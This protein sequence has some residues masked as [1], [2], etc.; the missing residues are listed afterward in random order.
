MRARF[1]MV[2]GLLSLLLFAACED[3]DPAGSDAAAAGGKADDAHDD[4]DNDAGASCDDRCGETGPVCGCDVECEARGDCCPDA[5]LSCS[6]G[7]VEPSH[8]GPGGLAC[9]G[10]VITKPHYVICHDD[11][12]L[13]ARWTAYHL[14]ALDLVNADADRTDD[15]RPE[16]GLP[17]GERAELGD[18]RGSGFDRGHMAPAAD[19]A[20][21][22]DAMSSTF[23][24]ANMAPQHPSLNRKTWRILEQETRDT[25]MGFGSAWVFTGN[26]FLDEQGQRLEAPE[27]TLG[28]NKVWVPTHC[29]K[30]LLN[31]HADGSYTAYAFIMPNED[32]GD[33]EVDE[34]L[35]TVDE[36]EA[37]TG[38]DFF[39]A[40]DDDDEADL[41]SDL[42]RWRP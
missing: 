5:A 4:D 3:A 6:V 21:S 26:L 10:T 19:F 33:H 11:E 36:L 20:R 31:E 15:F 13:V 40:L 22:D 35:V 32:V 16:E 1:R 12:S 39:A 18:Y 14:T 8:L 29:F 24:L 34:F 9:S 42:P 23:T 25:V 28:E 41:E 37:M 30:T 2:A 38:L 7:V 17:S 27:A